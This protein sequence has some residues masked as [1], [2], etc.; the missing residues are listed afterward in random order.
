MKTY[1]GDKGKRSK[2]VEQI[3]NNIILKVFD[4]VTEASTLTNIQNISRA[5]SKNMKAGG[6]NWRCVDA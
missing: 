6:F 1:K 2:K 3:V 5:V 4:S